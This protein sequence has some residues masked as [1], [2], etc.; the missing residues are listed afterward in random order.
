MIEVGDIIYTDS[1]GNKSEVYKISP[2][3]DCQVF[4]HDVGWVWIS[5]SLLDK[6]NISVIRNKKL[7]KLGI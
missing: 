6:W 5:R 7:D 2:N 1:Q 4:A 3:G